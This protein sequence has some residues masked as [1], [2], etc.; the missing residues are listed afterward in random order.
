MS[1]IMYYYSMYFNNLPGREIFYGEA[2]YRAES[3]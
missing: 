2:Y 1:A 3:I